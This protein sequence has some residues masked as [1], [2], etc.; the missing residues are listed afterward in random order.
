MIVQLVLTQE[1][2]RL[3]NRHSL[4]TIVNNCNI[5]AEVKGHTR[6][7]APMLNYPI[8]EKRWERIHFDILGLPLSEN[9]YKYLLV[10]I[11]YF[12][13]FCIL[14]PIRNKKAETIA[15]SLFERV[16]CPFTTP[17]TII[18]DNGPEFNNAIL[19]EI[20]RLFNIKN[21]VNIQYR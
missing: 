5:C 7:P 12:S 14:Q 1:R 15:T 21:L 10:F 3:I 9:G 17:R 18:T 16:I 19:V 8:P 11:D 4:K 20:C 2:K 13:S 6:Q